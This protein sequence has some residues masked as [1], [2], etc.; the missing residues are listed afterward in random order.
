MGVILI[1]NSKACKKNDGKSIKISF[2]G[3]FCSFSQFFHVS[4]LPV[5]SFILLWDSRGIFLTS[6]FSCFLVLYVFSYPAQTFLSISFFSLS[7]KKSSKERSFLLLSSLFSLPS[8]NCVNVTLRIVSLLML[9]LLL[10]QKYSHKRK[11]FL[12]NFVSFKSSFCIF[13]D[14]FLVAWGTSSSIQ[15]FYV[16]LKWK[17]TT[18]YLFRLMEFRC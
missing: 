14:N 6:S 1:P 4:F 3:C 11:I 18:L 16:S 10:S 15:T 13:K 17:E 8:K 7:S 12:S 5:I 2:L 9:L